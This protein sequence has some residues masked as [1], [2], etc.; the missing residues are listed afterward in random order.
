M[1]RLETKETIDYVNVINDRLMDIGRKRANINPMMAYRFKESVNGYY[2]SVRSLY[3]ILLPDL[4]AN[5]GKLLD[6]AYQLIKN[7]LLT[8]AVHK[9]DKAVEEMVMQLYNAGLL[10]RSSHVKVGIVK[11]HD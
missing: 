10:I 11:R 7:D 8:D 6:E 9:I 3:V 4:R 5:A 2:F 1:I